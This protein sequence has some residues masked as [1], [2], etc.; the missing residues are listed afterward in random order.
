MPNFCGFW[1]MTPNGKSNAAQSKWESRTIGLLQLSAVLAMF[2]N[3]FSDGGD[4]AIVV[5]Q[6][7][8]R[9]TV[10]V[11]LHNPAQFRVDLGLIRRCVCSGGALL[12][13]IEHI[14]IQ[15]QGT[16]DWTAVV[17]PKYE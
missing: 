14:Q 11:T 3:A 13:V 5:K 4:K 2:L 9:G 10:V 17:Y 7:G 15:I 16:T 1:A 12:K 8:I 6:G